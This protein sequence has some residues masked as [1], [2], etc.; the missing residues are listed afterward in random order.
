MSFPPPPPR[1]DDVLANLIMVAFALFAVA[2]IVLA[3]KL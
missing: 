2:V 1:R 3:M